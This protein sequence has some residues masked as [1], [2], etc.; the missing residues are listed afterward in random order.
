MPRALPS[1]PVSPTAA[2]HSIDVPA[3][4]A[5]GLVRP[6]RALRRRQSSIKN[7]LVA[8][9]LA[10]TSRALQPRVEPDSGSGTP[11]LAPEDDAD[12]VQP[13]VLGWDWHSSWTLTSH[14]RTRSWILPSFSSQDP[15]SRNMSISSSSFTGSTSDASSTFSGRLS[16]SSTSTG[17]RRSSAYSGTTSIATSAA[18]SDSPSLYYQAGLLDAHWTRRYMFNVVT[19]SYFNSTI[20]LVIFLNTAVLAVQSTTYINTNFGWYL[21]LLDQIFLGV[22]LMETLCKLVVFQTSYF[23]SGWNVFDF[24]IVVSSVGSFAL[25]MVS[26]SALSFNPKVIRLFRVFRA[27]RAIRSLRALRAISF[28]KS[29]QIIVEALLSSVP[30]MSSILSLAGLTLYIFSVVGRALYGHIDQRRFGSMGTTF[31]W[32]FSVITLD[33]WSTI[34]HDHPDAPGIFFFLFAF[35]V[36]ESFIFLNLFVAVIVSNLEESRRSMDRL[37]RRDAKREMQLGGSGLDAQQHPAE[38]P[39]PPRPGSGG[40]APAGLIPA[41]LETSPFIAPAQRDAFVAA[42]TQLR[43]PSQQSMASEQP[44]PLSPLSAMDDIEGALR[45]VFLPE[46]T[47]ETYYAPTLPFRD[48]VLHTR[49]LQNTASLEH[50]MM[51]CARLG[52]LSDSLVDLLAMQTASG[53]LPADAKARLPAAFYP[54]KRAAFSA[55]VEEVGASSSSGIAGKARPSSPPPAPPIPLPAAVARARSGGLMDSVR[56]LGS[57]GKS[58]PVTADAAASGGAA[59]EARSRGSG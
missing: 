23:R 9:V 16:V 41:H 43:T 47:I 45:A 12:Q 38:D 44:H 37:R 8:N 36:L 2:S 17:G 5:P 13:N 54:R 14:H 34:W 7:S 53:I 4:A 21:S 25:T 29:L 11:R 58:R 27:F 56:R 35:L 59:A 19:S 46:A 48:Q 51:H 26:S 28:L 32:L 30:A 42:V 15:P 39:P 10:A 52:G 33:D 57:A 6:P 55:D 22:Y 50:S 18:S 49:L 3:A 1:I 24:A 40:P 20:L 31:F